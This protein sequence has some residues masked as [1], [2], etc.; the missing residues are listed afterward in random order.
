[1]RWT[2][3]G[4]KTCGRVAYG[5][6]VWFWLPDAGVKFAGESVGTSRRRWWLTSPA[7]QEERGA[8]VKPLRRECRMFRPTCTDLWALSFSAHR[9]CGCGQRPAFPAPSVSEGRCRCKIRTQIAPR[10]CLL[11]SRPSEARAG[12]HNH[13]A[14]LLG[15]AG[16]PSLCATRFCGYGSPLPARNCALGGDDSGVCNAAARKKPR[17]NDIRQRETAPRLSLL[18]TTRRY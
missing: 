11:S 15:E 3:S 2:R 9:A 8:A 1:M 6:A 16:T 14:M 13:R 12:T 4:R 5:Q 10:E 7:H 18:R 17:L